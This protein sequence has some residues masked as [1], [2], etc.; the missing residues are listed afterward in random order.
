MEEFQ[1]RPDLLSAMTIERRIPRLIAAGELPPSDGCARCGPAGTA[2]FT[3]IRLECERYTARA[4]GGE[5]VLLLPLLL[6]LLGVLIWM[7]WREE[8]WVEIRGRDTDVS[9]PLC[10]C[11]Q[12][13]RHLRGRARGIYWVMGALALAVGA[14][15][16]L[17][18]LVTGIGVAA[19]GV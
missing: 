7:W 18:H 3:P 16:G 10:L 2:D 17:I 9:A 11:E 12:C 1:G 19:A 5:R 13:R 14:L 6:P 4:G 15:V 8:E